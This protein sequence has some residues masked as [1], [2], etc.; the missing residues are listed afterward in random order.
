[1]KKPTHL[2]CFMALMLLIITGGC[3]TLPDNVGR[4]ASAAYVDTHDT[5]IGRN[6]QAAMAEHPGESG[7]LLL[8]NGLDAFVA[9]VLLAQRAERIIDTQYYMI[10]DDVVGSLFVDQLYKAAERGVRVRLLL[11]AFIL[12]VSPVVDAMITALGMFFVQW[13]G[14]WATFMVEF[15][16][17]L[18]DVGATTTL[19]ALFFRYLPNVK[20]MNPQR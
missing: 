6:V 5:R 7:Y 17:I 15:D 2:C 16:S 4:E 8:G 10:H 1:M 20:L 19:F 3:A 9:R 12:L 13:A 14:E 11:D 18:L